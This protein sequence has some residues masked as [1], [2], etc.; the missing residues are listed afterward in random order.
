MAGLE[1]VELA[2]LPA[3]IGIG[4][5]VRGFTGFGSSMIYVVGLTF[6]MPAAQAVPMILM[7]E[8]I[9]TAGLVPSVWRLIQWR[10][11]A[12]LLLGSVVATPIGLWL[13]G[14]LE[15]APMQAVIAGVVLGA[16]LMLRSGFSGGA[17]VGDHVSGP[18][19]PAR[20]RHG[21]LPGPDRLA[22][23]HAARP[24]DPADGPRRLARHYG[25][26]PG[27]P[28]AL[29]PLGGSGAGWPL[30]R[31]PDE[32]AIGDDRL[33]ASLSADCHRPLP[34]PFAYSADCH[35]V[36]R[37]SIDHAGLFRRRGARP[38]VYRAAEAERMGR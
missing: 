36:R 13:L 22:D 25:L 18:R 1:W 19:R 2:Y 3:V 24:R 16:C 7:L 30:D 33:M 34:R 27:R 6:A 37:R 26:P 38:R 8:V 15:P 28:K 4:A 9:T 14:F 21:Q 11:L 32:S 5:F 17:G 20:Q 10:S 29:S 35:H 12:L 23:G 31:E